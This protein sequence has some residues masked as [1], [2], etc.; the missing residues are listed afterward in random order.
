MGPLIVIKLGHIWLSQST[1]TLTISILSVLI[2]I[3]SFCIS[4]SLYMRSRPKLIV[5]QR[6]IN[7]TS[8][9]IEPDFSDS[10]DVYTGR[11]YRVLAEVTIKNQSSQPISVLSFRLNDFFEY[12][13][14]TKPGKKYTVTTLADRTTRNGMTMFRGNST[15]K[16]FPIENMWIHPVLRLEP[17]EAKQ[18]YL[19]WTIYEDDLKR[20]HLHQENR[21]TLITTF[22][23]VETSLI[24]NE[25]IVRDKALPRSKDWTAKKSDLI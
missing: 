23:D 2:A 3:F 4:A 7:E 14:F 6:A 18:G 24:I 15:I 13:E 12:N 9:V 19:F 8:A 5:Q 10:P 20:I 1:L 17:F 16:M 22:R 21:L 11:R 25:K